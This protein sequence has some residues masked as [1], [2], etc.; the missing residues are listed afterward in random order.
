[1]NIQSLLEKRPPVAIVLHNELFSTQSTNLVN[2]AKSIQLRYIVLKRDE[3]HW[4]QNEK[5]ASKHN[6]IGCAKLAHIYDTMKVPI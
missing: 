6:Y 5:E 3:I 1:M 2:S 4:Y